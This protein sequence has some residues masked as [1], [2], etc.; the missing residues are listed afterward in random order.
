MNQ[1][2]L[3]AH[4]QLGKE[5]KQSAEMIFGKLEQFHSIDFYSEEGLDSIT[6]KITNKMKALNEPTLVMTDLFCGT[7]YNASCAAALKNPQLDVTIVSG[8]SL[9]LIL[10]IATMINQQS[11]QEVASTLPEIVGQ[12]V[13][14]FNPLNIDEDDEEL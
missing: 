5:M 10:E 9:P 13:K 7:P 12:T 2:I 14:C 6:D 11:I 1:V 8:M 3:V 4:G